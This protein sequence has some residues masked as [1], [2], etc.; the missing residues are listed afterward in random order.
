MFIKCSVAPDGFSV[1]NVTFRCLAGGHTSITEKK[2]LDDCMRK[3]DI[4]RTDLTAQSRKQ[5]Q[6]RCI[7]FAAKRVLCTGEAV[8][9]CVRLQL[10]GKI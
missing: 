1:P 5:L 8:L 4:F 2:C 7:W 9:K 10:K 6:D 3:T